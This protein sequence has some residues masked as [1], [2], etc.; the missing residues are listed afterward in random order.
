MRSGYWHAHRSQHHFHFGSAVPDPVARAP[1]GPTLMG[2]IYLIRHGQASFGASDY[3]ELSA[4]GEQQARVLGAALKM[5]LPGIGLTV[6]GAMRRHRQ[7]AQACLQA[8]GLP[9]QWLEDAG[10]NEYDHEEIIER[11]QPHHMSTLKLRFD[12]A[13][14][15]PRRAFQELFEKATARWIAGE[16]DAEYSESWP[17]FNARVSGALT[18]L[19]QQLGPSKTALVFTSGGAITA[20]V[21]DLMHVPSRESYRI[22]RIIANA[23]VTKLIYGERGVHLSTFNEHAHFEGE[24]RALISYR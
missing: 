18:R 16:H 12:M 24:Q 17:A 2:A 13:G 3:D 4:L 8:M 21:A 6:T 14:T 22:S 11:Y 7:T 10:W 9:P 5:R 19:V 1:T 23:S 20:L 15:E